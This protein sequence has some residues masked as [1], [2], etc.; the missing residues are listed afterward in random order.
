MVDIVSA[1]A[2][3]VCT[4]SVAVVVPWTERSCV[5]DSDCAAVG[6]GPES[7]VAKLSTAGRSEVA[8]SSTVAGASSCDIETVGSDSDVRDPLLVS[9]TVSAAVGSSAL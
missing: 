1:E 7:T 2:G 3:A 4:W 8:A 5:E 9:T 6:S